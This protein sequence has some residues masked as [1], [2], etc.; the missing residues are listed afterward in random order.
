MGMQRIEPGA[1][2]G[3]VVAG[4]GQRVQQ[5]RGA[6]YSVL[7]CDYAKLKHRVEINLAKL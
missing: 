3:H 6:T 5:V 7:T 4:L 2:E 1:P